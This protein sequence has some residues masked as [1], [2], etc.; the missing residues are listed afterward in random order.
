MNPS[1]KP[2]KPLLESG[3]NTSS[4]WFSYAGLGIGVVLLLCSIQMYVNLQRLL[5]QDSTRK[6]G[7]DFVSVRKNVTNESMGNSEMNMFS[8]AEADELSK[9]NFIAGVAPLVAN[10]FRLQLSAGKIIDFKTDFFIEAID[11][12]FIDTVPPA[13][14]WQ[15]G[16]RLIPMIVSSDFLEIYNVFAP[17]Y[18][19]PQ[20]SE[21][22]VSQLVVTINCF[23]GANNEHE[24]FGNI[25]ALSD[26]INSILV[27][28]SFLDWGNTN[29]GNKPVTKASRLYIKTKDANNP[30]LLSY[31]DKKNYKVNKDKTKF[32]RVKQILQG[33]FTGLGVFGLMVVVLA[34][35]LFSFYLQ[36]LIARSKDNLQ[37]LLTLGYS[38]AWLSKNVARQF[39]P[40]YITVVLAALACTQLMQWAFHQLV[41]NGREELTSAVHWSVVTA[42]VFLI[43]LSV[44]TNFRLIKKLLYRFYAQQ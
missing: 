7:F 4:R 3:S 32:G 31:L 39:I 12:D 10:N 18:G 26:R 13:F 6:N 36:L 17:G 9:Q 24:F 37:L 25:V 28:K 22:T 1:Y 29:F 23:D 5:R 38:P 41:M 16:Q 34:L 42:A 2:I 44:T 30:E 40:V 15:Q 14:K 43:V 8:A 27:P 35:M 19:L 33:V 20:L 21:A 11:N